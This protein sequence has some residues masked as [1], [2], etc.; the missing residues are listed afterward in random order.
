MVKCFVG[1][2]EIMD[3]EGFSPLVCL[4]TSLLFTL[5]IGI[6]ATAIGGFFWWM[7]LPWFG[8]SYTYVQSMGVAFMVWLLGPLALLTLKKD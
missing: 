5:C 2:W 7:I 6:G 8:Y 4:L 3:R 1:C